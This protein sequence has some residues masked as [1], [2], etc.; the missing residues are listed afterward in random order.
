MRNFL[1]LSVTLSLFAAVLTMSGVASAA[2]GDVDNDTYPDAVDN[3]PT[4]YNVDFTP[5]TGGQFDYDGD[6]VGNACDPTTG[7]PANES[8]TILYHR[9]V[10]TGGPLAAD[11]TAPR[12]ATIRTDVSANGAPLRSSTNCY[13]RFNTVFLAGPTQSA[14][15]TLV[16][17]PPGCRHLY[18]SPIS[19]GFQGGSWNVINAYYLCEDTALQ[20]SP[21]ELL[22]LVLSGQLSL[23]DYQAIVRQVFGGFV[24]PRP[25]QGR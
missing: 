11:P 3:C 22:D 1:R 2:L 24:P 10:L 20:A 17:E 21:Q 7:I 23:N 25:R 9:D 12:C 18:T 15:F 13:R 5:A 6:G 8:Y 19:V 14:M 4:V 16:A